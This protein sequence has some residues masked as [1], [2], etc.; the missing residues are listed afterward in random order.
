M[1]TTKKYY[2]IKSFWNDNFEYRE[3]QTYDMT[4][5]QAKALGESRVEIYTG[6]NKPT[7][8][9]L[10]EEAPKDV[11]IRTKNRLKKAEQKRKPADEELE[12]EE[13]LEDEDE[14][15]DEEA[16][17]NEDEEGQETDRSQ[18]QA[19]AHPN[20]M[21]NKETPKAKRK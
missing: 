3:G 9:Y 17:G 10:A 6:N 21:I 20:K 14:L 2:A 15:D 4:E 16:E 7:K 8:K 13:D 5:E 19:T 1:S 11:K 12:D 18:K